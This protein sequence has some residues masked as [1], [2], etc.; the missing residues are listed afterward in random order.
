[1]VSRGLASVDD[2]DVLARLRALHPQG[3]P[4]LLGADHPLPKDNGFRVSGDPLDWETW[5]VQAVA[6]FTP[7]SAP[8]PSGLRPAH[9]KDCLKRPGCAV[10]LRAGLG[11]FT[12]AE[13][14]GRLSE[15]FQ[16][17][18]CASTLI[19][20]SKKDGGI[21]PIAVGDTLRR[22]VGKVLL[23]TP[24]AAAQTASLKPRQTGVGMPFV[25]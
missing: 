21:R 20:L 4:V 1:L 18:L 17:L 3:A 5:A 25:A 10:S 9:L 22:L 7:G 23:R 11:S 19:P 12:Q 8:G 6:R 13:A 14:D 16:D 2:P 24:E 15:P